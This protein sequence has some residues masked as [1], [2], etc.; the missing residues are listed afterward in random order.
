MTRRTFF[1]RLAAGV[2]G[3]LGVWAAKAEQGYVWIIPGM[4]HHR[5]HWRIMALANA[6][7]ELGRVLYERTG[8][9]FEVHT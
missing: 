3:L 2:A 8:L 4:D 5:D 7:D 6:A 1:S 9:S